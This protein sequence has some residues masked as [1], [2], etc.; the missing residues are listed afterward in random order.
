MCVYN[1]NYGGIRI[2]NEAGCNGEYGRYSTPEYGIYRQV[3]CINGKLKNIHEQS[4][5]DINLVAYYFAHSYN[6]G[7]ED[8]YSNKILGWVNDVKSDYGDFSEINSQFVYKKD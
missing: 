1:N 5:Y 8:V 6:P 2:Y 7:H 4:V 3:K